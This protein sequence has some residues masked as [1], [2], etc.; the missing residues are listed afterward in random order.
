MADAFHNRF[1]E[2]THSYPSRIKAGE[3]KNLTPFSRNKTPDLKFDN[4]WPHNNIHAELRADL[5]DDEKLKKWREIRTIE[6]IQ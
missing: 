5:I 6:E 3:K 1:R 4:N 2:E